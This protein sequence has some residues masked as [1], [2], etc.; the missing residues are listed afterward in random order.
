MGCIVTPPARRF[1]RL[2]M[3]G[4]VSGSYNGSMQQRRDPNAI[5]TYRLLTELRLSGLLDRTKSTATLGDIQRLIFD[6]SDL[7]PTSHY[8]AQ[9]LGLFQTPKSKIDDEAVLPV[10]QDAWNYFPHRGLNGCAPAEFIAGISPV[11]VSI[12]HLPELTGTTFDDNK[13]DQSVLALLLLGLHAKS[14]VW[15]GHSWSVLDRL[16]Q[17]GYISD[18]ARK[19]KSVVL[20]DVGFVKAQQ[21]FKDFFGLQ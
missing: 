4:H 21:L 9:I 3:R 19:A 16:F 11:D 5:R 20:T 12:S 13:I 17:K 8:F 10:I 2:G 7:M 6:E 1:I 18:P 14:R 15:K